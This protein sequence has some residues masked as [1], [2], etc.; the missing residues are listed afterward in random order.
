MTDEERQKLCQKVLSYLRD[1]AR[2]FR[3]DIQSD[4]AF[5]WAAEEIERLAEQLKKSQAK[6]HELEADLDDY[7]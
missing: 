6:V 2:D 5:N 4:V 1:P 7:L 3:S